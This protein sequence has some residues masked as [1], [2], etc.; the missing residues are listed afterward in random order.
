[1]LKYNSLAKLSPPFFK[2]NVYISIVGWFCRWCYQM[3]INRFTHDSI[4]IQ[5]CTLP[6]SKILYLLSSP[7]TRRLVK[8]R[9]NIMHRFAT[10]IK[11]SFCYL[12]ISVIYVQSYC[13]CLRMSAKYLC[14]YEWMKYIST[15]YVLMFA[16]QAVADLLV[17]IY[18]QPKAYY[19]TYLSFLPI[20]GKILL[21][22]A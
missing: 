21:K 11:Q 18:Q 5:T 1:M 22:I 7:R 3:Q 17:A 20:A 15:F 2:Y 19:N 8:I 10:A 6:T 12:I 4:T 14:I 9:L 16:P 13:V